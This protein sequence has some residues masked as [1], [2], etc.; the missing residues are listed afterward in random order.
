MS[1]SIKRR[2]CSAEHCEMDNYPTSCIERFTVGFARAA[3]NYLPNP[4]GP[5]LTVSWWEVRT[6]IA[7]A[8][9]AARGES[10]ARAAKLTARL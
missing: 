5:L 9:L 2:T 3:A 7:P 1:E 6:H 4:A 10:Q 8:Q